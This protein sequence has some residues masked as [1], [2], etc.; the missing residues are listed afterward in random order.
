LIV[1]LYTMTNPLEDISAILEDLNEYVEE[2]N[3]YFNIPV[4]LFYLRRTI[5]LVANYDKS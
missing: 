2:E 3:L 4:I 5:N 1:K